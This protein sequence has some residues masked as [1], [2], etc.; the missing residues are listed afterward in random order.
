MKVIITGATGLIGR[1]LSQALLADGHEVIGL[2]RNPAAYT[3]LPSGLSLVQWDARTADG[4]AQHAD[5]ADVIVNLA[6]AGIADKRWTDARK[7]VI[8]ESR[9]NA[10]AAVV[11]GVA[12]AENKPSLVIQASG[13]GY[14]GVMTNDRKLTERDAAGNDFVA[15]VVEDWEASTAPV[16][17]LGVRRVVFRMG[18]VL[19]ADGGALERMLLPYQF[20]AGGPLGD[21]RQ[22]MSWV[23]IDDVVRAF[24]YAMTNT[25]LEGVYNLTSPSPVPNETLARAIGTAVGRPS[26]LSAPSIAIRLVFGEMA[27]VVLDGQRVVPAR[28]RESGFQFHFSEVETAMRDLLAPTPT[29]AG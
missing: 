5:G 1:H 15:D 23:H 4:W 20:Y 26:L 29:E 22:W 8:R 25:A 18:V 27:T 17:D 24:L 21:G 14:Y 28:L 9:T 6:G 11:A 10:G 7:R 16:E 19:S 2:S 12:A 3:D 13:V